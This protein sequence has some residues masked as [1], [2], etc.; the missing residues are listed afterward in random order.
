[1]KKI[2]LVLMIFV[3]GATVA[4][5]I[6]PVHY[7]VFNSF[8]NEPVFNRLVKYLNADGDQVDNLKYVFELTENRMKSAVKSDNDAAFQK[9]MNFNLANAKN[10]LSRD[11]YTKYL[12]MVNITIRNGYQ[13]VLFSEK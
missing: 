12:S 1:M 3:A 8:N 2:V 10:I 9:A 4:S 7:K 13:D 11:Q 6:N 5:A